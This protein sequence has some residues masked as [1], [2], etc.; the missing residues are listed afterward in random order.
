M[1]IQLL[2]FPFLFLA[3]SCAKDETAENTVVNNNLIGTWREKNPELFDGI[4]DTIVFTSELLVQKHIIFDG[5]RYSATSD[6][7][8]FH[9]DGN[10]IKCAYTIS[11][12]KEMTIYNFID[13]L[14]TQDVK[15]IQFI[16]IR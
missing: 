8:F 10:E 3:L 2:L 14:I 9:K 5:W 4:S 1:K 7:I 15:N 11:N 6:T 12:R 16:R 13:R